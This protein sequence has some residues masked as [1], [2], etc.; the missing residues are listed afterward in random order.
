MW[1]LCRQ[2]VPVQQWMY[3]L[4]VEATYTFF[5]G[6][7]GWL[8]H[9]TG[10][11][12]RQIAFGHAADHLDEFAEIG[13]YNLDELVD[14][15]DEVVDFA[16]YSNTS[17]KNGREAYWLFDEGDNFYGSLVIKDPN[18]VDGGTIFR[19]DDGIDYFLK[20]D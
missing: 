17:L 18:H 19:L 4:T 16:D 3:N 8:V 2:I 20:L 1:N 9:N 11:C 15:V 10:P 13:I 14:F 6:E 5:V 7:Q 12:G